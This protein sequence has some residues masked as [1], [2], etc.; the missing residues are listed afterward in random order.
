[1]ITLTIMKFFFDGYENKRSSFDYM[2]IRMK[3]EDFF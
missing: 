1:L 2:S 3:K